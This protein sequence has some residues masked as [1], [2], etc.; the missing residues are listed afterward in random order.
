MRPRRN[1]INFCPHCSQRIEPEVLDRSGHSRTERCLECQACWLTFE[2][3]AISMQIALRDFH[4]KRG[5]GFTRRPLSDL[6][7]ATRLV[8]SLHDGHWP[9]P[10]TVVDFGIDSRK[11]L[12]ALGYAVR[13]GVTAYE[14]DRVMGDGRAITKLVGNMPYQPF[15]DIRFRTVYDDVNWHTVS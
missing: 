6:G 15:K 10:A 12:G 5:V 13:Y 7:M 8:A 9:S 14:L 3:P 11:H 2:H 1:S 4:L